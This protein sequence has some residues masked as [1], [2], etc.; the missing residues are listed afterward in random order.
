MKINIKATNIDLTLSLSQYIED[1]IGELDKFIKV[2]DASSVDAWVEIGKTTRHHKK[3]DICRAEVQ[4][5]LP[6][7]GLR[8]EASEWDLRVSIDKVKDE[9]QREL[10][11]Y[12]EKQFTKYKKGAGKAKKDIKINKGARFFRKGRVREEGY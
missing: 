6:G 12:K 10:K 7:R 3:G 5:R 2:F 8:V 1:K 11:K 4:I 9:L